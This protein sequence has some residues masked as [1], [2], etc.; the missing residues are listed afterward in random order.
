MDSEL[1]ADF[2]YNEL[3]V[4]EYS[5]HIVQ[6]INDDQFFFPEKIKQ[7]IENSRLK[8]AILCLNVKKEFFTYEDLLIMQQLLDLLNKLPD[9]GKI[10]KAIGRFNSKK[11][12]YICAY[13]HK[14]KPEIKY[15]EVCG[16]D[17]KGLNRLDNKNI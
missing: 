15:C 8:A 3:N 1:I 16:V 4:S 9:I 10:E 5:K 14:N 17:M 6:I 7:L 2:L 13:G 12:M 11:E